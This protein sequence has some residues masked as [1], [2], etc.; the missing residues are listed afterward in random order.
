MSNTTKADLLKELKVSRMP[1]QV[2][3]MAGRI[4][5]AAYESGREEG[6]ST[7]V[8]KGAESALGKLEEAYTR[9]MQDANKVSS[10]SFLAC[11]AIA[12]HELYGFA[13]LRCKRVIDKVSDMLL[14]TLHPSQWAED[15]RKIGVV[16]DD[17]D[18]LSEL[19]GGAEDEESC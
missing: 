1:I 10:S 3:I 15:C 19:D 8:R 16:I 17:V 13:A 12:L 5:D 4:Y 7:G 11:T 2:Q 6:F 18:V 14:T 9:G